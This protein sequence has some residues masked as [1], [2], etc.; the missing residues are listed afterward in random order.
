M[1]TVFETKREKMGKI[2]PILLAQYVLVRLK[3]ADHLKLQKLLYYVQGWHLALFDKPLFDE[4]FKAWVHGPVLTSVWNELKDHSKLYTRVGVKDSHA[5]K[6]VS[7]VKNTLS[8]DQL[9]L[10]EDVLQEY[11]TKTGYHLECLTH[12]EDPW[13]D[14]RGNLPPDEK[15]SARISKSAMR[16]FYT[17]RLT[18]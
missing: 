16:K 6:V 15:C 4:D 10:I 1:G 11:G 8:K 17:A 5:S 7:A 9:Q 18:A 2:D 14:A 3:G 13:R 12:S